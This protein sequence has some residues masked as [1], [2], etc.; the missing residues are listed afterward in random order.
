[1]TLDKKNIPHFY[2]EGDYCC[3]YPPPDYLTK[4]LNVFIKELD[5][6]N[7]LFEPNTPAWDKDP[8]DMLFLAFGDN[9]VLSYDYCVNSD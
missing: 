7:R 8:F 3:M 1:M 5:R 4:P 6:R 2:I 9:I